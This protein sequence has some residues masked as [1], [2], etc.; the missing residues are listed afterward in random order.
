MPS[1]ID[2]RT[3]DEVA[4]AAR[5]PA[6]LERDSRRP[7]SL[8]SKPQPLG[9]LP[10]VGFWQDLW[11]TDPPLYM[12]FALLC[13]TLNAPL[14]F[15]ILR[16]LPPSWLSVS[17]VVVLPIISTGVAEKWLRFLVVRRRRRLT[18]GPLEGPR[19]ELSVARDEETTR[20]RR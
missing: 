3:T 2:Q 15:L 16:Y 17:L 12:F 20:R 18:T 13:V 4:L 10:S 5:E 19:G 7:R 1:R 8:M 6:A 9:I 11:R 14:V